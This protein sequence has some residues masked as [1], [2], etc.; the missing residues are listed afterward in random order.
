M[1]VP[2]AACCRSLVSASNGAT[3]TTGRIT[4]LLV[5]NAET[6]KK[7]V[8]VVGKRNVLRDERSGGT[9]GSSSA[10]CLGDAMSN[11]KKLIRERFR[12]AVF[13]RDGNKCRACGWSSQGSS[14][15]GSLDAHHITDRTLMPNGGYCLANGISLCPAHHELAEAFHSTGT[16]HPGFAPDDLYQMIGSSYEQAV[17]DA[18]RLK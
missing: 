16:A 14:V 18:E 11:E 4:I 12:T 1:S 5:R 7:V 6:L 3:N 17:R 2:T 10:S 9:G 15:V 8:S 13:E